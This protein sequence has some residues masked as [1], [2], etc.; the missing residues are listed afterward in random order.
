MAKD[1]HAVDCGIAN[2]TQRK[3]ID[4]Q[5]IKNQVGL[6]LCLKLAAPTVA[7]G[8]TGGVEKIDVE[9]EEGFEQV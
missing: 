7:H 9:M 6:N 3:E 5:G 4:I 8:E 1:P 2:P